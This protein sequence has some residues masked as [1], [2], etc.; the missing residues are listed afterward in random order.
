MT[1]IY[2]PE[3]PPLADPE[4]F[5]RV[6]LHE[7]Q[8][9]KSKFMPQYGDAILKAMTL[10]VLAELFGQENSQIISNIVPFA[11]SNAFYEQI[12]LHYKLD[13]FYSSDGIDGNSWNTTHRRGDLLEGYM[14]A[15]EKD[16]LQQSSIL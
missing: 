1:D 13:I 4:D 15:I 12:V 16:S 14:A 8:L 3:L 5:Q 6:F 9:T 10:D 7:F 11:I 2:A